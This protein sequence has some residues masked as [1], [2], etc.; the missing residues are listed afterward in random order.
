MAEIKRPATDCTSGVAGACW[1]SP[2]L[3]AEVAMALLQIH[4]G[5]VHGRG[6][7]VGGVEGGGARSKLQKIDRPKLTSNCNQQDF[8]F[9]KD[10]WGTYCSSIGVQPDNIIWDQLLQCAEE[11]LRKTLHMTLGSRTKTISSKDMMEEIMKA[12]A[13][14]QSDLLN[15]VKLLEARQECNEPIRKFLE[16]LRGLATI[17]DLTTSCP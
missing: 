15:E 10:E 5:D 4:H 12:A 6:Q 2:K 1:T 13:E 16:R 3:P 17:C 8:E 11:L 9:F 14:K 7:A